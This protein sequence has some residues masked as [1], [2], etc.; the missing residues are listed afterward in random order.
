MLTTFLL[1]FVESVT[2]QSSLAAA[3]SKRSALVLDDDED[4][5]YSDEDDDWDD[6]DDNEV[7]YDRVHSKNIYLD[8]SVYYIH[9][10]ICTAM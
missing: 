4:M 7:S 6:D 2:L 3:L 8:V 1:I 5:S 9:N 10:Y